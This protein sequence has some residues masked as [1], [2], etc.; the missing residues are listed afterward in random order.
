MPS[1]LAEARGLGLGMTLAHQHLDQLDDE[2]RHAV[3][4][5]ARSRVVFQLPAAD[6]R[7]MAREMGTILSADDLQGLGAYE[8]ACQLFAGGTTQAPA[9]GKTRP[10]GSVCADA[11]VIRNASRQR[12]GVPSAVVEQAIRQRQGGATPGGVGRRGRPGSSS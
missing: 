2:A 3:L 8:V 10:L 7:M 11:A 4:A 1:M 12:Y 9:T 6:A 5:N